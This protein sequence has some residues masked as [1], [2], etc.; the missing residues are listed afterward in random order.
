MSGFFVPGQRPGSDSDRAHAALRASTELRMGCAT[1]PAR[2]Y[3]L[4]CRR[5][6]ADARISVGDRDPDAGRTVHAIFATREGYTVVWDGGHTD[7]DRHQ[8]YEAFPFED[9][10][11]AP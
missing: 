11:G 4:S 6:G 7:L 3:G 10:G 8:I 9:V 1:R 2:I 5:D